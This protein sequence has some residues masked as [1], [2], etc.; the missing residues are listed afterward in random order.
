MNCLNRSL[1]DAR[2]GAGDGPCAGVIL[3]LAGGRARVPKSV[4]GELGLLEW[5]DLLVFSLAR[6]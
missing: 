4:L 5:V 2:G 3:G 1:V 6:L